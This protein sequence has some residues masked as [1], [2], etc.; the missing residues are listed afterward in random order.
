MLDEKKKKKLTTTGLVSLCVF[1]W[2]SYFHA[3]HPYTRHVVYPTFNMWMDGWMDVW[4]AHLLKSKKLR[5]GYTNPARFHWLSFVSV[6]HKE[7]NS[8]VQSLRHNRLFRFEQPPCLRHPL[9]KFPG[10]PFR[11][12]SAKF[13]SR[14]NIAKRGNSRQGITQP[15]ARH[16]QIKHLYSPFSNGCAV[17]SRMEQT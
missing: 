7:H 3:V 1:V 9:S 2:D 10:S 12:E 4:I 17:V 16:V 15:I 14:W 8:T 13:G 11:L 5:A 6:I